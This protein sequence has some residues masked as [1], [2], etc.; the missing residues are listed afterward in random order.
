MNKYKLIALDLDETLVKGHQ[1]ISKRNRHWIKQ[2]EKVGIIVSFATG[3]ARRTSEQFWDAV[4]PKSP[5]IVANGAE[6][7]KNHQELLSRTSLPSGSREKLLAL[8]GKYD[9]GHWVTESEFEEEPLKFG[10][11][12]EE[13][14][15]LDTLQGIVES[16]GHYEVS[17]SGRRNIEVTCK[18][19]TKASG[20]VKV[21]SMLGIKPSEVVA[22]GDNLNDL[23]MIQWAG[24][25]VAME[26][27][28]QRVKD[29]AD[30]VT[31]H[32]ED[33]GVAQVLELIL[34]QGSE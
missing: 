20:L 30:Y 33:D 31:A 18:G 21:T 14:K 3:R 12:S 27:A 7:W 8:A 25:G 17:S 22:V 34:K 16:W 29:A 4:S 26:N 19:V 1:E 9:V 23:A 2:I 11:H 15:I 13:R 6:V 5:M 28:E 32:N 10:M 24:F